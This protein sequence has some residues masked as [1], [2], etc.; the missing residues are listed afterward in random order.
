METPRSTTTSRKR[1]FSTIDTASSLSNGLHI[2]KRLLVAS[3]MQ[4]LVDQLQ[5]VSA[6]DKKSLESITENMVAT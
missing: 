2:P 1:S 6:E 3:V 4:G 5:V